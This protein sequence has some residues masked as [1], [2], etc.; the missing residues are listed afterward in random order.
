MDKV[1]KAKWLE[2][3]RSGKYKQGQT[4]LRD[5]ENNFCCLG[6]LCDLVDRNQW[7]KVLSQDEYYF[8]GEDRGRTSAVLPNFVIDIVGF[9]DRTGYFK[10]DQVISN[11]LVGLNDSGK[12]FKEI[13]DIIEKHF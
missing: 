5:S 6:V 3:L 2:A 11:S 1:W 12:S 13:A 9:G 8:F 10:E 7:T 4:R